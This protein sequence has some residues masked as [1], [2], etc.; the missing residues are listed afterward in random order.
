V[1]EPQLLTVDGAQRASCF[2]YEQSAVS[3][4]PSGD[5]IRESM[6]GNS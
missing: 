5:G 2:L 4:R 1:Q 3:N 6:S